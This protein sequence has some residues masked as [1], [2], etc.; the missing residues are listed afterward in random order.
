MAINDKIEIKGNLGQDAKLVKKDGKAFVALRVATTNSYFDKEKGS[1]VNEETTK[2]HSVLVFR[3]V[4]VQIAKKL[5][6][7]ARVEITGS[8]SYK[9]FKGEDGYQHQE[10]TIIAYHIK[11]IE[12]DTEDDTP[13]SEA[14]ISEAVEETARR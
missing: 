4:L 14:E 10:M 11:E 1:W 12:F 9:P 2:W 7:G 13:P 8:T 3:P 6:K 5:K